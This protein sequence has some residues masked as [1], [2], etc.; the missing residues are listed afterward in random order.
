MNATQS[1]LEATLIDV[2]ARQ[3]GLELAILF[4][5]QASGSS[6]RD[7]DI[8]L[9]VSLGRPMSASERL[10]LLEELA[11]ATG[12][13]VDLVD[14]K[15]AGEPLLGQIFNGG[16]RLI[17]SADAYA[18]LLSRHLIDQADFLP[19]RQRILAERRKAWI[20]Q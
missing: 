16:K 1:S 6:R 10:D 13:A 5:S 15:R 19:Y 12:L 9:A 18:R 8:D 7:S 2:L 20:G 11:G 14:L 4:G 3:P 17:G